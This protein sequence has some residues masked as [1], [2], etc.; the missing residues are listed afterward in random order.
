MRKNLIPGY[1]GAGMLIGAY[2]FAFV[3]IA[4]LYIASIMLAIMAATKLRSDPIGAVHNLF[5]AFLFSHMFEAVTNTVL[6]STLWPSDGMHA[7]IMVL[8][9]PGTIIGGLLGCITGCMANVFGKEIE[10]ST[11]EAKSVPKVEPESE[12]ELRSPGVFPGFEESRGD[13]S[14]PS[15]TTYTF[16]PRP[17]KYYRFV[18]C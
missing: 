12:F 13:Q 15:C 7:F 2:V 6:L 14:P 3:I 5:S 16:T 1:T 11:P 8:F 18:P 4:A 9:F 17:G 10:K